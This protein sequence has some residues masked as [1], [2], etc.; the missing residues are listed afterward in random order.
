M[1]KLFDPTYEVSSINLFVVGIFGGPRWEKTFFI[2]LYPYRSWAGGR[3]HEEF[4][5]G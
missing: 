4:S 2:I 5:F 1:T 3:C